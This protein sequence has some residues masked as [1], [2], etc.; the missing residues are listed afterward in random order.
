MSN[1]ELFISHSSNDRELAGRLTQLISGHFEVPRQAIRC[2]SV[3][4]YRLELGALTGEQLQQELRGAK[5]VLAVL[6]PSSLAAPWVLYE[7]GAAWGLAKTCIP[8]LAGD[9]D[10][11]FKTMPDPLRGPTYAQLASPGDLWRLLTSLEERLGWARRARRQEETAAAIEGIVG[12]VR[13][14]YSAPNIDRVQIFYFADDRSVAERLEQKVERRSIRCRK[15]E[16]KHFSL[17]LEG[18]ESPA[19][20]AVLIVSQKALQ[21][22]EFK[23]D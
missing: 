5:V 12:H 17:V 10:D 9:I 20:C 7:M 18:N 21:N 23:T 11:A 14:L 8:L 13:E 15:I 16:G 4:G 19:E 1:V 6:T 2:S 3:P 22:E